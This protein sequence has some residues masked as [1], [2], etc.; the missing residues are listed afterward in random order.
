MTGRGLRGRRQARALLLVAA[1]IVAVEIVLVAFQPNM[2]GPMIAEAPPFG[3][4]LA[5]MA[6]IGIQALGLAWMIRL[7]PRDP[8]AHASSWRSARSGRS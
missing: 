3:V 8:E 4:G 7:Y 2:M 1:L 6:G 5:L